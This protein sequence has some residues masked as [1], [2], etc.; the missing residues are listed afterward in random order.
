MRRIVAQP[1]TPLSSM[2]SGSPLE[3]LQRLI[4]RKRWVRAA[5]SFPGRS[6]TAAG[7]SH[8]GVPCTSSS[9]PGNPSTTPP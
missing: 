7:W 5:P 4:D 3:H 6:D 8:R 2:A 1:F 9:L